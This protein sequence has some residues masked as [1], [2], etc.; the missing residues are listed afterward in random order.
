MTPAISEGERAYIGRA[1]VFGTTSGVA[2]RPK[3]TRANRHC[4]A[5]SAERLVGMMTP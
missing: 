5:P 1:M 3:R 2:A 4:F